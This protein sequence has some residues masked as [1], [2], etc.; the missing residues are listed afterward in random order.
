MPARNF[1][2]VM[3]DLSDLGVAAATG[4][5]QSATEFL[6]VSSSGHLCLLGMLFEQAEISLSKVVLVH[7]GTLLAT[8]VVL[9]EE[10]V[11]LLIGFTRALRTPRSL[12]QTAEGKL[13]IALLLSTACTA[14]VAFP[15]RR[16]VAVASETP[17]LVAMGFLGSA[18]AVV[19]TRNRRGS[20]PVPSLA[21][22]ALI[23]LAQA[24]AVFPGVSRSGASIACA[25]ALNMSPN[26]A[27]RY[28]FL[29]SIPAVTGATL[30]EVSYLGGVDRLQATAW[31]A[32]AVAF[33]AGLLALSWLRRIVSRGQLWHF[34]WY[35]VPLG[36]AVLAMELFGWMEAKP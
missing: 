36:V 17:W 11:E 3:A 16:A 6:P 30:L 13:V 23:G 5:L 18:V 7:T 21:S 14:A 33:G 28:S 35:L 22:A 31:T 12:L 25:V 24:I 19:S 27:F 15:L 20:D 34:A 32:A 29:L 10:I 4:L 1:G 2:A 9:R 8:L 26:A